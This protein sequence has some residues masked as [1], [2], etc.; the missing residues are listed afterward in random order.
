M[1]RPPPHCSLPVQLHLPGNDVPQQFKLPGTR[2]VTIELA[3]NLTVFPAALGRAEAFD[4]AL[5]DDTEGDQCREQSEHGSDA[6]QVSPP[7]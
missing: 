1:L 4:R 7:V 6:L 2:V 5:H 3:I